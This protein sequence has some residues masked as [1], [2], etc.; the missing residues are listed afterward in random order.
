[1]VD[2]AKDRLGAPVDFEISA[3][4]VDKPL[5]DADRLRDRIQQ[6]SESDTLWLT[7]ASTFLQKSQLFPNATFVAGADTVARLLSA[8]YYENLD[9]CLRCLG[10]IRE[11]GCRFLAFGRAWDGEFRSGL[12]KSELPEKH[13]EVFD[14]F[15]W[16]PEDEFRVD[17]SSTQIRKQEQSNHQSTSAEDPD[18]IC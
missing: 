4:N 6:F 3:D 10:K 1:M 18:S 14:M 15:E 11:R 13:P 8:N 7:R 5:L 2:I 9:D 17:L 12:P 16:I